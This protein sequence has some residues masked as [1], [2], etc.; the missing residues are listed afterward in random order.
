[1]TEDKNKEIYKLRVAL[2]EILDWDTRSMYERCPDCE[3]RGTECTSIKT[4]KICPNS[5]IGEIAKAALK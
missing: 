1:V 2:L 4:C 3:E 5:K